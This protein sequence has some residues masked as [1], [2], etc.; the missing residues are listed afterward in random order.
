M[1]SRALMLRFAS[2]DATASLACQSHSWRDFMWLDSSCTYSTTNPAAGV[3]G[4]NLHSMNF[5]RFPYDV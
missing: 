2:I 3:L 5:R 4:D 1:R